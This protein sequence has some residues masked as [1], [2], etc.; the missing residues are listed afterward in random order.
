MAIIDE[1]DSILIDEARVPL[2]LSQAV[3]N[4]QEMKYLDQ[5]L[6]LARE[7][8]IEVDFKLNIDAM[9]ATLT[10]T[11]RENLEMK[12]QPLPAVWHNRLHREEAICQAL[13]ALYLYQQDHHYLIQDKKVHI[14]DETTGRIAQGRTWSRGLHQ[15][16]ELKEGCETSPALATLSQIT[17][18]RLFPRYLRL[19]GVSGTLAESRNELLRVYGLHVSHVPLRSPNQREILPTRLFKHHEAL[20]NA[21]VDRIAAL[22]LTGRPILIG[23]ES[24][25]ESETLSASLQKIGLKHTVLNARNDQNEAESIAKAGQAGAVTVTTNTAGR[26]TDIALDKGINIKG[27]LH[28]ISCQINTARRIDRQL[29]GRCARQGDNGSVETWVSL[30]TPLLKNNLPFWLKLLAGEYTESLPSAVVR[31]AIALIQR[32]E[33]KRH[34][35]LRKHLLSSDK[36]IAQSLTFG[37]M[38]D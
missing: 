14:V 1:A 4:G 34:T 35:R 9:L 8:K 11:G 16:I 38:H 17:Y 13:A 27:G 21:L 10:E 23:T 3:D 33:E 25:A 18:Q 29:A 32:A 22:Q 6:N 26:G 15:L 31:K 5:S 37:R 7:L 24:V 2:I 30:E 19:G 20:R 36:N 12:A 28:V